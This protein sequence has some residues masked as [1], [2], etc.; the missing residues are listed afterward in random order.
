[1]E[2]KVCRVECVCGCKVCEVMISDKVERENIS[3]MVLCVG[4]CASC[5]MCAQYVCVGGGERCG[6]DV[7]GV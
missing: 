4:S 2:G 5:L 1:M 3:E 6:T 7:G